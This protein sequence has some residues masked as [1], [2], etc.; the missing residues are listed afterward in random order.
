LPAG[1]KVS[2]AFAAVAMRFS[3]ALVDEKPRHLS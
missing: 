3:L 1:T 2:A